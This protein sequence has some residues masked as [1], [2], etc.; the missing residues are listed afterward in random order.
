MMEDWRKKEL[1]EKAEQVIICMKQMNFFGKEISKI[2][3]AFEFMERYWH[4][5]I[6]LKADDD[7]KDCKF[8]DFEIPLDGRDRSKV[9]DVIKEGLTKKAKE[10]RSGI[11]RLYEEL[12]KLLK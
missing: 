11:L 12:D 9:I 2:S 6:L 3:E 7:E 5:D 4:C 8:T 1:Q 10:Y